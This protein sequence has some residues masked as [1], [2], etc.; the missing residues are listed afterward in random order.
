MLRFCFLY[1]I[2]TYLYI[3]F[4][5][6][7]MALPKAGSMEKTPVMSFQTGR[8]YDSDSDFQIDDIEQ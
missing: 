7:N 1:L 3:G 5:K 6:N 4:Q 2:Y 8:D